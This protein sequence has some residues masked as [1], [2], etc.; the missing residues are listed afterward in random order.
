MAMWNISNEFDNYKVNKHSRANGWLS[1]YRFTSTI[2]LYKGSQNVGTIYFRAESSSL[3]DYYY[4]G[5]S[6]GPDLVNLN[7]FDRDFS[8]V[9]A[10]LQQE[11]PL[12]VCLRKTYNG[13]EGIGAITTTN[14][15]VGEEEGD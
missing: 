10:M 14:E 13:N 12:Y 15:P 3:R 6:G 1:K 4:P 5:R 7:Y 2:G 11:S 9:L 8:S